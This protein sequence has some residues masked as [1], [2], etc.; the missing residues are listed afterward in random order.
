VK[1]V[2]GGFHLKKIDTQTEETIKYFKNNN[3]EK[4]YPSHCTELPALSAFYNEFKIEQIKT[5]MVL[6]L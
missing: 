4:L 3:I 2:F 1:A 6:N 5:G